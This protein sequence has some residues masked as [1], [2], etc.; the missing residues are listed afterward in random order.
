MFL[1]K[2]GSKIEGKEI[3]I[4]LEGCYPSKPKKYHVPAYGFGIYLHDT[5]T[6]IGNISFRIGS[7]LHIDYYSGNIG[8][9]V[10]GKFR[11][12][13]YAAKACELLKGLIKKHRVNFVWITCDPDNIASRKTCE[14]IG[15]KFVE[16]VDI[17]KNNELYE[18]GHRK[19]CR[20]K[21]NIDDD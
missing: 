9:N 17:P 21:W 18:K 12:R 7:N 20:Y 16:I 15:A 1:L 8:Y 14:I 3:D 2:E 5:N 19:K 4:I 6:R 10:D 13:R 11:G